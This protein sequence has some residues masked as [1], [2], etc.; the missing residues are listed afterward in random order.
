[1][2]VDTVQQDIVQQ[3]KAGKPAAFRTVYDQTKEKIMTYC[4]RYVRS[5]ENAEELV[6]DIYLRLWSNREHIDPQIGIIGFLYT[7]AKFE[8]FS[9][10]KKLAADEKRRA[11]LSDHYTV[12]RDVLYQQDRQIEAT[13]DLKVLKEII[14]TFP[15]QRRKIFEYCKFDGLSYAEV[16]EL[17]CI[18]KETVKSHMGIAMKDL[19]HLANTGD[20]AT[21]LLLGS[22][23]IGHQ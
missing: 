22:V 14:R 15:P 19:A 8:T 20:F 16:A 6:N 11:D 4:M 17:L 10:L 18:N 12:H 9:Y 7:T 2:G 1:M 13:H 3:F 23:L 5:K 21:L